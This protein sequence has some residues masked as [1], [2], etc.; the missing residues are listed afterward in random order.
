MFDDLIK[1]NDGIRVSK[2]YK[3]TRIGN[4][5]H[6][7]IE[8]FDTEIG[9]ADGDT[10][11]NWEKVLVFTLRLD[12]PDESVHSVDE[13]FEYVL[14]LLVVCDCIYSGDPAEEEYVKR[15]ERKLEAW[16]DFYS[17]VKDKD[18]SNI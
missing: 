5:L 18:V 12:D 6:G 2:E 4:L 13:A 3:Y 16:E 1:I 14:L 17:T 8:T 9:E 7:A 15:I 10:L 11:T